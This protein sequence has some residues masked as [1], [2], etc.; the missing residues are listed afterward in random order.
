MSAHATGHL[1]LALANGSVNNLYVALAQLHIGNAALDWL[2]GMRQE[3][4]PCAVIRLGARNG[5]VK[6]RTFLIATPSANIIGR[7]TINMRRQT[8]HLTVLTKPKHITI[9]SARGP[10]HVGG[11][12]RKPVFSV[13]RKS[14]LRAG[15]AVA[16][17][18]LLTPAAALLPLI[19]TAPGHKVD[20]PA[21]LHNAGPKAHAEALKGAAQ[22]A[23]G[24]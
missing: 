14:L 4:I 24:H 21:S 3:R 8:L 17:G 11:T 9:I 12:F 7:G 10:L 6:T 23:R 1:G 15:A 20:C 5:L 2:S 16:L 19:D 18:A 22:R 13:S